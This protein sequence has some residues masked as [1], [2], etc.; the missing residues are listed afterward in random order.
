MASKSV[1]VSYAHKEADWVRETLVPCLE[2]GGA[3]VF[4]DYK[5]FA[6]GKTVV[7]QMDAFQDKAAVNVLVI[8]KAYLA[9][10]NCKH[11]MKRAIKRDPF[12]KKGVVLPV[13]R[14]ACTL[15]PSLTKS[16]QP[17][18]IDLTDD[19]D[20]DQW[21]LLMNAC[22]S[23]LGVPAPDWIKARDDI[24]RYLNRDQSVNFVVD[25]NGIKWKELIEH[26]RKDFLPDLSIMD[27]QNG[28]TVPRWG[29]I[30]Q[31]LKAAGMPTAVP[32]QGDE[33]LVV[34]A[35]SFQNYSG[36]ARRVAIIYFDLAGHREHY[37]WN[38]Y[39]TVR[40]LISESRKLVLLIQSH[41]SLANLLPPD[42]PVSSLLDTSI[43]TVDLTKT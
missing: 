11:E 22:K 41:K 19:R 26:I 31:L 3:E 34:L 10:K 20:A 32:K 16:S 5:N 43:K 24:C 15:P 30:E 8:T 12:F 9:S 42:N 36:S 29:F 6:G 28:M 7:G 4:V 39:G 27:L 38:L 17:L 23:D 18:Y 1:F 35:R 40:N 21:D 2:A 37:N 14:Q 13:K 25:G 33:D